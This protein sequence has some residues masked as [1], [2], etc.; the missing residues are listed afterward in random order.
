MQKKKKS[1]TT[2]SKYH[3]LHLLECLNTVKQTEHLQQE[4]T[5]L[6]HAVLNWPDE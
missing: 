6:S 5:K 1:L 2:P 4:S 3:P